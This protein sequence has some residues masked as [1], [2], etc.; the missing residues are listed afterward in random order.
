MDSCSY[1]FRFIVVYRIPPF[2]KNNIQK[3]TF[4]KEFGDLVEQSTTLSRKLAILGDFNVHVD[5]SRESESAQ[6]S[7]LF[8]SF[9][10]VQHVHGSIHINGHT[11]GPIITRAIDDLIDKCEVGDFIFDH[12][13]HSIEIR[14]AASN[15]EENNLQLSERDA[16]Q[17]EDG[18]KQ[19]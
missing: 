13:S 16:Q 15:Q 1:T 17:N 18:G 10:L 6:L 11:M 4:M 9:G 5:S 8:E 3:S 14:K 19:L 7:T 2:P 12:N